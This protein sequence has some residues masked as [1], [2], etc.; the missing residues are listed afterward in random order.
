MKKHTCKHKKL[1]A[2]D[3]PSNDLWDA[4]FE[5]R[6]PK[7]YPKIGY[8]CQGCEKYFQ[9]EIRNM[10]ISRIDPIMVSMLNSAAGRQKLG[11][12]LSKFPRKKPGRKITSEE[13][14][15]GRSEDY[16]QLSAEERWAEDKDNGI[17][18]WEA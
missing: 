4:V 1:V 11:K 12:F 13:R 8:V 5:G 14:A 10:K 9:M 18:D 16:W 6:K 2:A 3:D 7:I 17:L 15:K